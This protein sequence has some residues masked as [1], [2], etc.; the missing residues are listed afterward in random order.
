MP[1]EPKQFTLGIDLGTSNSAAAIATHA[2]ISLEL[3]AI[4]QRVN[5]SA[6]AD[7]A[8]LPSVLYFLSENEQLPQPTNGDP[9]NFIVG[10]YARLRGQSVP[11]RAIVSS[12]SW[13]CNPHVDRRAP[14]LPWKSES[15]PDADKLSPLDVAQ[16]LLAHIRSSVPVDFTHTDIVVAVPASFDE[17]A[18]H[19]TVEAAEGAGF[20]TVTLLEEPLAAFYAWAAKHS[21]AEN[22]NYSL[23]SSLKS[24]D[25]ILV[26]DVG[27]GTS[28]FTLIS[29]TDNDGALQLE[30][31]SV[32]EHI[33][34]G[35]DNMDLA[36]AYALLGKIEAQGKSLDHWQFLALVQNA[37]LAKEALLSNLELKEVPISVAGKS[38][39]LF[40]ETLSTTLT[41]E[42]A[43]T[44]ILQG[45][46]PNTSIHSFPEEGTSA[47]LLDFGLAYAADPALSRHLAKFLH[48]SYRRASTDPSLAA[49]LSLTPL[50]QQEQVILPTAVLFNGGVFHSKLLRERV[51]EFLRHWSA[52][53]EI[54]EL[55]GAEFD[56]A[57]AKGAAFYGA[58]RQDSKGL[59]IRAGSA[60]SFY[61]GVE[62][63][64]PAVP[65]IPRPIRGICIL[66]LGAEE[67]TDYPLATQEFALNVG[68]D[69]HFR[70]FSSTTRAEDKPGDV[71]P[72]PENVLEELDPLILSLREGL[73][74][75][76]AFVP[77][78][79][80]AQFTL[81][82]V[83]ELW[84]EH[85]ATGR[86]WK[87]E[88]NVRERG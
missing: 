42:Q 60:R 85:V 23:S 10:A 26:C 25:K 69:A 19:L 27:G 71:I 68:R 32:G 65:G 78:R 4:T 51:L 17:A 88:L 67:G 30:R 8:L 64:V 82:G 55:Q 54:R 3:V 16:K 73:M 36:L 2:P 72:S 39:R 7:D 29:V 81:L 86:K 40:A 53:S 31:L 12:K 35:G 38:S 75:S 20:G 77:V 45:Y 44:I 15:V 21:K 62:S 5:Q 63:A 47:G 74:P 57:V 28:D 56:L 83:L 24:G 13:L 22:G 80:H 70:F 87:L 76:E 59:R 6:V 61:V 11:E 14:I 37:R 34:L 41:R 66:P 48:D 33:L 46:F 50:E 43:E 18:R 9:E 79:L 58:M 49:S 52:G 1:S 84:M